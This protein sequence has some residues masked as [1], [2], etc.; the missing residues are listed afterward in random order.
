MISLPFVTATSVCH[1]AL[2]GKTRKP[3]IDETKCSLGR[4]YEDSARGILFLVVDMELLGLCMVISSL[5]RQS[6]YG[7]ETEDTRASKWQT[8]RILAQSSCDCEL[9]GRTYCR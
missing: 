4:G 5:H 7:Q 6:I 1:V 2:Q 3:S 9:R 8:F